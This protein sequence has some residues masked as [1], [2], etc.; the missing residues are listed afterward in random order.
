MNLDGPP[1]AY[2]D[3]HA[4]WVSEGQSVINKLGSYQVRTAGRWV[5][6]FTEQ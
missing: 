4:S 3:G 6:S 2:V 5:L 1:P